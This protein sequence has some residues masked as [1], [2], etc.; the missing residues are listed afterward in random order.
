M[1]K[2]P[3]EFIEYAS[4]GVKVYDQDG[5]AYTVI[6]SNEPTQEMLCRMLHTSPHNDRVFFLFHRQGQGPYRDVEDDTFYLKE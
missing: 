2:H 4:V 6:A 5:N 1:R 3:E